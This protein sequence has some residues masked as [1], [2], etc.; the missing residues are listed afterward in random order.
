M[1]TIR[2]S[3]TRYAPFAAML[4]LSVTV[5]CSLPTVSCKEPDIQVT[6]TADTNDGSCTGADC[7]LREAVIHSNTCPGV[8]TIHIPPGTY[9]LT[10]VGADEDLSA[11]G[12]LDILDTVNIIGEGGAAIDGNPVIDGN[13][14]DRVI[15]V[16]NDITANI[17]GLT[18][19]NGQ[20]PKGGPGIA[21]N[22]VLNL[23]HSIVRNN[24]SVPLPGW[25]TIGGG[26][27]AS[28]GW[29][30]GPFSLSV[31]SSEIYGNSASYG[32]GIGA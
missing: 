19:Q 21:S 29:G 1:K 13:A 18:I 31:D 30:T 11:T 15:Q 27:S 32:G 22:G 8:Q 25:S 10:L 17:T 14:A 16:W 26:V 9:T 7:S 2:R 12:D 5:S 24:T 3:I 28:G 23:S 6:K 4:I 20:T